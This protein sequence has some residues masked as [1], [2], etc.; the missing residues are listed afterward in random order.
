MY[1]THLSLRSLIVLYTVEANELFGCSVMSY[2]LW[3]MDRSTPGF[4]IS[5]SLLKL[6]STESVMPCNQ[7]I[8]CCPFSSCLQSSK[9]A[10]IFPMNWLFTSGGQSIGASALF[11]PMTIQSWFPLALTGLISQ[12]TLRSLLQHHSLKVSILCCSAFFCCPFLTSVLDYWKIHSFDYLDIS[13]QSNISAFWY[14]V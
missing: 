14:A 10:V 9:A 5:R 3:P 13:W 7:L 8:L 11:L 2:C 12:G 6:M 1:F 4:I